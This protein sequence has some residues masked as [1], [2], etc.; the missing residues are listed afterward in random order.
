MLRIMKEKGVPYHFKTAAIETAIM[1]GAFAVCTG[2][3]CLL[4][5]FGV[6]NLN[7]LIIYVLGILLTAVFTKGYVYSALLSLLSVCGYNFFF[8]TP[9]YT[10]LF[11]DQSY[12]I[13]FFLMLIVGISISTITYQLKH[14]MGQVSALN[15][16]KVKLKSEAEK[17]QLKATLLASISHDLRTPL[18]TMKNGAE[19]LLMD[20]SLSEEDRQELLGD[21]VEKSDWII[22][23][24]ENLLS[25][26]RIDREKLT[27]KKSPEALE[28]IVPQAVRTVEGILENRRIHYDMPADLLLVPMDATLII[29]TISNI[30]NNAIKHTERDGNIEIKVWNTGKH[31]VFRISNDGERI[32]EEDLPHLFEAYYTGGDRS[33]G[34][35]TGLGLSICKLIVA[36]HGGTIDVR[37]LENGVVFEFTL[38]MEE[39]HG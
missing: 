32:R 31:A 23:L 25:L 7:F 19:V 6:N 2:I 1:L 27:V 12:L 18:T 24:V 14:K 22:R 30:L 21:I 16:E 28:E 39:E 3:C 34:K 37:N 26:S 13:T 10:F 15:M 29:Q 36:A 38:P 5:T 11:Q 8:T 9:R 17:E 33:G 20:S 4:D 35:G